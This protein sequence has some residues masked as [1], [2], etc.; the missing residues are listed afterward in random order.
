MTWQRARSPQEAL[1]QLTVEHQA[2]RQADPPLSLTAAQEAIDG[3]PWRFAKSMPDQPH[4]YTH[5]D[6]WADDPDTFLALV[7]LVRRNGEIRYYRR[8]PYLELDLNGFTYWSMGYPIDNT[9]I[10]NR[11]PIQ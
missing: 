4:W 7:L 5:Q 2:L 10:L 1:S 11:R 8:W 3:H 6:Q 9:Q